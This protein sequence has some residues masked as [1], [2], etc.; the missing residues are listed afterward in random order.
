MCVCI[1]YLYVY[2]YVYVSLCTHTH[3]QS[4]ISNISLLPV[5]YYVETSQVNVGEFNRDC[6]IMFR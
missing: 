5:L 6:R 3:V 1:V 4:L 2:G